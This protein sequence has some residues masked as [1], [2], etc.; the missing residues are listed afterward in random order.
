MTGEGLIRAAR[1][2]LAE[3]MEGDERIVV[4]GEDVA[5]GGMFG[6][7]AELVE[8]F[9][10]QRI[11]NT[12]ISEAAFVGAAIG[13]ALGGARPLVEIMFDDFATLPADQLFN[14]AAKIHF[15][16]G[17]RYS[18][19]LTVWTVAGAGTRQGAQ[20]SQHLE[21]LFT[22]FAGLKVLAPASPAMMR[23]SLSQ[24]LA[25]PDPVIVIADRALL[26]EAGELPGDDGSPWVSRAIQNGSDVTIVTS[27]RLVGL[28]VQ[29]AER[30][31]VSAAVID[32]QCL[33]PLDLVP[34][35]QSLTRTARLLIVHDEAA[36]GAL[37][38]QLT[39]AV[40]ETAFWALD[41]PVVRVSAPATPVPAAPELEDAYMV[42]VDRIADG[43]RRVLGR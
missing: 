27:G 4:L 31:G 6:L 28:A 3:A 36:T 23:S 18:V 21:G 33:A 40:Y 10:A 11:R 38:A 20:H 39:A 32:L 30:A 25:D 29:A 1:S 37:T 16:S 7:T 9:G 5:S 19:P 17:G 41:G 35:T 42:T 34:L 43:V 8:R 14:H 12:P 22:Q 13:M 26:E 15:M 2:A 24:A